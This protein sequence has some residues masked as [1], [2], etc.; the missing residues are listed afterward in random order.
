MG[1]AE[2]ERVEGVGGIE[3]VLVRLWKCV[4]KSKAGVR[5]RSDPPF[6]RNKTANRRPPRS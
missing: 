5:E 1:V 2:V 6:T 3:T 4:E